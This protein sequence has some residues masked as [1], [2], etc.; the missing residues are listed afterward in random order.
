MIELRQ[1]K[2]SDNMKFPIIGEKDFFGSEAPGVIIK[3]LVFLFKGPPS[4]KQ[5]N[6]A[7]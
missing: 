4:K 3:I 2:E 5:T 1:Y 6:G 7:T